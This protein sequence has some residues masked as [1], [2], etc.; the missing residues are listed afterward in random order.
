VPEIHRRYNHMPLIHMIFI[1]LEI[2]LL[3]WLLIAA[4]SQGGE[5]AESAKLILIGNR[6]VVF[7]ILVVGF[8]MIY[9][10]MV[11]VY[12][13]ARKTHGYVSGILSG[14]GIVIAGLFVRYLIVAA[15]IPVTL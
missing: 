5:A 12:A 4:L 8:G 6:S 10:F 7:W 3:A 1:G 13:F 11:H 2:G 9:P 14:A 15:A